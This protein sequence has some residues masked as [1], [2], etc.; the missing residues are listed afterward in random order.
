[1]P[2][3]L[4]PVY[5]E[6]TEDGDEAGDTPIGWLGERMDNRHN[7]FQLAEVDPGWRRPAG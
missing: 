6:Q 1:M 7:R 2:S 5:P 3:V 4:R